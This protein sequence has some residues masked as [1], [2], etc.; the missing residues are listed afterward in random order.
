M[1]TN[2]IITKKMRKSSRFYNI[3]VRPDKL[4]AEKIQKNIKS[5]KFL[6]DKKSSRTIVINEARKSGRGG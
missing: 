6:E 4:Y 5:N 3:I 2:R 1:I